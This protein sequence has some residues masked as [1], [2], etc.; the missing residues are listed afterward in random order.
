MRGDMDATS[1]VRQLRTNSTNAEKVL[2]RLLRDRQFEGYKFRRQSP[3]GQY[4]VDFVCFGKRLIIELDGG[5]HSERTGYDNDR[6]GWLESRGF[7]VLRFWNS[8]VLRQMEAATQVILEAL[9][10]SHPSTGSGQATGP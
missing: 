6:T 9:N 1:R 5:Q 10:H 8:E 2:W 4:I 7:R 3:I